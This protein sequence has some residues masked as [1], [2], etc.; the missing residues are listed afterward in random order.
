MAGDR[1]IGAGDYRNPRS[2]QRSDDRQFLFEHLFADFRTLC[3][4]RHVGELLGEFGSDLVDAGFKAGGR[5]C[6][7][8]GEE[9]DQRDG[10][11][12]HS[13]MLLSET[14]APSAPPADSRSMFA[15]A[16]IGRCGW[17]SRE[18]ARS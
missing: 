2:M 8:R 17:H 6:R 3:R 18:A 14:L 5:F 4:R 1:L 7:R 11:I 9:F 13:V 15:A 12:D 10:R 16:F